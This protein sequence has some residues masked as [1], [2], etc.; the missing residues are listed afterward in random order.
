M[1]RF[2]CEG[3][4]RLGGQDVA[5]ASSG[6]DEF[7][8][9]AFVDF[10]AEVADVDV[11]HVAGVFVVLVVEVFPDVGAGDDLAFAVGEVFEEGELAGAQFDGL[12]AA[13]Y[14]LG[15]GVDLEVGDA[16]GGGFVV[17]AAADHG[18][19]AGEEFFP[20]EGLDHVVVGAEVEAFDAVLNAVAGGEAED[21]GFDAAAADGLEDGPAVFAG[22]HHVEDDA[23]VGVGEGELEGLVAAEGE[24]DGVAFFA[25]A[26][27]D[28]AGEGGVVLGDED[29]HRFAPVASPPW[30]PRPWQLGGS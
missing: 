10:V 8:V 21:G 23:V 5:Q 25:E 2:G 7:G 26:V 17:V 27:G 4:L 29:T 9:E 13:L 3:V 14:G 12:V 16:D 11:H 30:L 20:G 18:A 1:V 19:D 28:G 15:G 24:V 6:V 22:E